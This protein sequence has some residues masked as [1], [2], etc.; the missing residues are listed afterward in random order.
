MTE[1]MAEIMG[2]KLVKSRGEEVDELQVQLDVK[3]IY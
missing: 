3:D 1:V 2:N